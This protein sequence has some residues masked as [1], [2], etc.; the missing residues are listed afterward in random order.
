MSKTIHLVGGD[1]PL[2]GNSRRLNHLTSSPIMVKRIADVS[3]RYQSTM[4][5]DPIPVQP[6]EP[7]IEY[8]CAIFCEFTLYV[9]PLQVIVVGK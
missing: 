9:V 1:T 7:E 4:D 3:K 5:Q 8:L 2:N 6:D